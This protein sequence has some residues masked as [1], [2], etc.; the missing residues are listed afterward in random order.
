MKSI[1]LYESIGKPEALEWLKKSALILNN[2][3]STI[4]ATPELI[5]KIDDPDFDFIN[6]CNWYD[7]EKRVELV[8]SFGGDGTILSAARRLIHSELPIMGIKVGRLGFFS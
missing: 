6:P 7:F 2:L 5:E 1:G 4:Y 3:G 8:I